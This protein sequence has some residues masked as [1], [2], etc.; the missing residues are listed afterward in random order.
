MVLFVT[1]RRRDG[2]KYQFGIHRRNSTAAAYPGHLGKLVLR[3]S[4]ARR[5]YVHIK[6][7]IFLTLDA[8]KKPT[9]VEVNCDNLDKT[10]CDDKKRCYWHTW[11]VACSCSSWMFEFD[12]VFQLFKF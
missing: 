4:K 2:Q 5:L 3:T 8:P 1:K 10:S 11:F 12:E 6:S 9:L 7:Y